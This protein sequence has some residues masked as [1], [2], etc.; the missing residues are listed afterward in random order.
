[1]LNRFAFVNIFTILVFVGLDFLYII[2]NLLAEF[3]YTA[4]RGIVFLPSTSG[5]SRDLNS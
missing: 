5:F 4:K 1:M 2:S 3:P